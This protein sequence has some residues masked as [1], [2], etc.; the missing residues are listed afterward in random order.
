M[1][2]IVIVGAGEF[3]LTAA[4]ELRRRGWLVTLLDPGPVPHPDA[5]STDISKVVRMDYGADAV[6]TE[7]GE[8]AIAGWRAWNAEWGHEWFH[9][10][11]FL[12]MSGKPLAPGTM[13]HDSHRFLA[14]RGHALIRKN[15]DDLRAEHPSWKAE[16]YVDG[17]LNPAG[18]WAESGKVIARLAFLARQSGITIEAGSFQ[19]LIEQNNRVCGVTAADGREFRAD[20]VL[21][22]A[23]AWTPVLLPQLK[24]VM[25]AT[26]QVV[27]HFRPADPAPW[28][29]PAFP[30]WAADIGSRGWYGFPAT[31]DGIVKVANH[32]KGVRV[33]DAQA[34]RVVPADAE[35]DF[36]EFLRGTFPALA[37]APLAGSRLCLYCDT[38]DGDFWIDHDPARP[39]LVVAAGDNGHAFKFA[40]VL[41]C[42]I[43]DVVERRPNPWAGRFAWRVPRAGAGDQARA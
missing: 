6:Y 22:T 4:L 43:A 16:A 42:L 11:G 36:R 3:G 37:E 21:V 17:Y 7:M 39:G 15:S 34:P 29:P 12:V 25:W 28:Q 23:G 10:D 8:Q 41:G 38:P 19:S 40:P 30:V 2:S 33:V 24:P 14:G 32:G 18:G 9:Q 27:L 20:Q 26:G 13:E 5:A 1:S 31:R 35:A